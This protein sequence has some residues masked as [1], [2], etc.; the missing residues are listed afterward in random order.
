MAKKKEVQG[1]TETQAP[2][3]VNAEGAQVAPVEPVEDPDAGIEGVLL[4]LLDEG[5][6]G[7]ATTIA[8]DGSIVGTTSNKRIYLENPGPS[9]KYP[10]AQLRALVL[11][12]ALVCQD[13]RREAKQDALAPLRGLNML[14][15]LLQ[16]AYD[17]R[18]YEAEHGQ[19]KG[20]RYP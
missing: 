4:A 16:R 18:T 15:T 17:V 1:A 7:K 12:L 9:L 13:A 3:E 2:L 6:F 14:P 20:R 5:S 8:L 10:E 11:W 19:R